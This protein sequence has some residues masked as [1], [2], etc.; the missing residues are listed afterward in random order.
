M[1]TNIGREFLKL[2]DKCFPPSH[3]LSKI[4][5]R[6]TVKIG[7]STTA[8]MQKIISGRNA[9]IFSQEG[10]PPRKCSWT[11]NATCPLNG[12][13]LE[14]NIVYHAKITQ[15][16]QK[17]TNYIGQ[18]STNFKARLAVHNQTFRDEKVS[19]TSLS[20]HI[21]NLEA[22]NITYKI[23]WRKIGTGRPFTPSSKMCSLCD[24]KKFNILFQPEI[25]DLNRKSEFYSPCM[26]IKPQLLVK[27]K[28]KG[29]G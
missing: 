24:Y 22:K 8:N 9:K 16:D 23:T 3:P 13:C 19:Q 27:K 25:A 15:S 5:N 17:V 20:K 18:T 14:N 29:P 10:T 6:S 26:H 21:R 7:Y 11:K 2:L 12:H 28:K 4:I 1:K